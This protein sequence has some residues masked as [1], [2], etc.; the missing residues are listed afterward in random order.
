ML[1]TISYFLRRHWRAHALLVALGIVVGA[2]EAANLIAFIPVMSVLVGTE[3][4][5]APAASTGIM[6][7]ATRALAQIARDGDPFLTAV[8]IFLVLTGL[9]SV[10]A[11]VYEFCVARESGRVLHLYRSELL[12]RL[13]RQPLAYFAASRAGDLAYNLSFPPYMLAKLLYTLPRGVIDFLRF[14]SVLLVLFAIEPLATTVLLI[15]VGILY[16]A[17]VRRIGGYSYR[18]AAERRDAEQAMTAVSTEWFHGIRPIRIA[19][20]DRHWLEEYGEES[21][22]SRHAH[23]R[24]Q[25]LLAAPRHVFELLAFTLFI[26]S[27]T[28]VYVF[29]P[30]AFRVHLATIGVF[31]LGL[32]RVLPSLAA[33]ARMPLDVRTAMPDVEQ[34]YRML[35][36]EAPPTQNAARPY[37]PLARAIAIERAT[38]SYPDRGAVLSE[39]DL[40]IAKGEVVAI[41]GPSG[42]GKSSLLNLLLGVLSPQ[43]GAVR[44]DGVDVREIDKG[45]YYSRVGYVGQDVLLFKGTVAE[46]IAFFRPETPLE[47]VRA[48]AVTAEI[49]DF[50]ESLPDGYDT[51]VGEG[52]VNLS[53][54]QAQRIAIARAI[55]HDPDILLLDEATSA[56]DSTAEAAVVHALERA[57][58]NRTVVTV[59]HR[60]RSARWAHKLVV[61]QGGR[62]VEQGTWDALLQKSEG[63]FA[64]MCREQHLSAENLSDRQDASVA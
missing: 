7:G 55:V 30:D 32:M 63:L 64:R 42:S 18:L 43:S 23:T 28:I 1:T 31:A 14:V 11:L 45:S 49:A 5:G 59:T 21:Q 37:A 40:A 41:V 29:F 39:V 12:E 20:A 56:L 33:L 4:L 57:A 48:A 6:G 34:L 61:L 19:H 47:D 15:A 25:L 22:R 10:M 54:G 44:L 24:L 13:R 58:V 9:K 2:L 35:E 17:V 60:L 62:I 8:L 38:V 27:V 50:I 16:L 26:G 51:A 46:N 52:G 36:S 53:G 3:T